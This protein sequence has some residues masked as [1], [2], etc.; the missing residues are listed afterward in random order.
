MPKYYFHVRNGHASF[1]DNEGSVHPSLKEAWTE[2]LQIARELARDEEVYAGYV[3][4][5]VDGEGY[6]VVTVPVDT[7]AGESKSGSQ[8]R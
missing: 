8:W 7:S 3:V 5:V 4:S 6:E 1:N 2:A